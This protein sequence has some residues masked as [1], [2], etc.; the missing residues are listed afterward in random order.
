LCEDC[1]IDA[2]SP[3]KTCDPWAT[4][5]ST[6]T[7]ERAGLK[8]IDSLTEME[9]TVYEFV[10]GKGRA[11]REE[12]MAEFGLSARDLDPQLN[13]LMHAELVKEHSEGDKM[14]LIPIG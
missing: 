7:T 12:V 11:T 3:E 1:Y 13:V 2:I 4:Y 10:R 14:Y 5:L 8:G 9:R 6:R